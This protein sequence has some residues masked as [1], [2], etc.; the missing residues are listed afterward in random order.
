MILLVDNYDSFTY[1]LAHLF[2]ELGAEVVVRRNDAIDPDE[3]ER[4]APSHLVISPGPGR[5]GDAG[6]SIGILRRLGPTTPT[7]GVCLGHQAIVEAFGG[8]VGQALELVHGKATEV[9]HDG[10]GVFAGLPER[11][12]VGRYHSLAATSIPD[13]LEITSHAADGEVMGV[14]HRELPIEGVQFHPE[15]VLTP[16]GPALARNF[17]EAR[18]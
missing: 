2:G 12:A 17:L 15:S 5:P 1:N 10:R 18:P 6:A 16:D 8:E 4:L 7:L 13:V 11:F 3:A 9:T 14:R